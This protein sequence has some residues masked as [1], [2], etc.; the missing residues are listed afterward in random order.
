VP[1]ARSELLSPAAIAAASAAMDIAFDL[2]TPLLDLL[3]RSRV[4][5]EWEETSLGDRR[6]ARELARGRFRPDAGG[7][8]SDDADAREALDL[9]CPVTSTIFTGGFIVRCWTNKG[10]RCSLNLA[11]MTV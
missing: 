5:S 8:R 6:A 1:S 11:D 9:A 4:V 2:A 10:P 3:L 7:R